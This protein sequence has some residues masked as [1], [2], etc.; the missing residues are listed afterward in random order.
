MNHTAIAGNLTQFI[1]DMEAA[2]TADPSIKLLLGETNSDYVNLAM[3]Q[4]EGKE[5]EAKSCSTGF[6]APGGTL[7]GASSFTFV[8]S[9]VATELHNIHGVHD[10]MLGDENARFADNATNISCMFWTAELHHI[11]N[12]FFSFYFS[13]I[14]PD[15]P[16]ITH[17]IRLHEVS[18]VIIYGSRHVEGLIGCRLELGTDVASSRHWTT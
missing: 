1:P 14:Y 11:Y 7:S 6:E 8:P 9:A 13:S 16:R 4:V 5:K 12:V 2:H 17:L 3:D 10:R 15:L 18:A